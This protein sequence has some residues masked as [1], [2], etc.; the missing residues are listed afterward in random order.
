[1]VPPRHLPYPGDGSVGKEI[2][3]ILLTECPQKQAGCFQGDLG[4]VK[5]NVHVVLLFFENMDGV[6]Y[7]FPG[8]SRGGQTLLSK[9]HKNSRKNG[10]RDGFPLSRIHILKKEVSL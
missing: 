4:N 7:R 6:Y 10:C 5:L 8:L 2:R 3:R 9:K 1:M